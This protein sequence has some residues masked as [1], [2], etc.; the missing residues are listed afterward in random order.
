MRSSEFST[1]SDDPYEQ[2]GWLY[3]GD[4]LTV[5]EKMQ[6]FEQYL[7]GQDL[8]ESNHAELLDYFLSLRSLGQTPV[9][10]GKYLMVILALVNDRVTQMQPPQLVKVLGPDQHGHRV[11]YAHARNALAP[12]HTLSDRMVMH[13]WYFDHAREFDQFRTIMRLKFNCHLDSYQ[14]YVGDAHVDLD[15][16]C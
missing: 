13:A 14:M 2:L 6:V 11:N 15:E 8:R 1:H 4:H 7:M 9:P 5:W 3:M 10:Q 12:S 16:S